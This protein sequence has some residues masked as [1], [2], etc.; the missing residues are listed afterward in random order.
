MTNHICKCHSNSTGNF[1]EVPLNIVCFNCFR[2]HG[3]DLFIVS[4]NMNL[5]NTIRHVEVVARNNEEAS[6]I[7]KAHY[8]DIH[9]ISVCRT[10][11]RKTLE[12]IDNEIKRNIIH[13]KP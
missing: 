8:A 10:F 9:V 6:S 1:E 5:T 3:Y 7:T 11:E 4:F 12:E 2:N 13:T